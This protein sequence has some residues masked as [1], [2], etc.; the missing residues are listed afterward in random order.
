MMYAQCGI[1]FTIDGT[2]IF[3]TCFIFLPHF[4]ELGSPHLSDIQCIKLVKLVHCDYYPSY[5][6]YNDGQ[7]LG[8][9]IYNLSHFC[10]FH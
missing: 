3:Y 7:S 4:R 5:D 9:Y 10:N 1:S 2:K 6:I 8:S